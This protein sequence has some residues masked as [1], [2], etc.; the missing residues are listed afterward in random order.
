MLGR[1]TLLSQA[2]LMFGD[3]GKSLQITLI[4][5]HPGFL[6]AMLPPGAFIGLGLLI[7]GRNWL[8]ARISGR[9]KQVADSTRNGIQEE[10]V[11]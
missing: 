6:L 1:G 8:D 10:A 5:D 4:P 7:A 9:R 11:T 2:H 3:A